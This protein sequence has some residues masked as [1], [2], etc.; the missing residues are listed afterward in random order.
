M[1]IKTRVS[2]VEQEKALNALNRHGRVVYCT[3]QDS[4]F[5]ACVPKVHHGQ[6]LHQAYVTGFDV[7]VYVV[8]NLSRNLGG[9][10]TQL[11]F[12]TFTTSIKRTHASKVKKIAE[13]L[14]GWMYN[15]NL[16]RRGY[17]MDTDFPDWFPMDSQRVIR[18]RCPLWFAA[19]RK[20]A[21]I[22]HGPMLPLNLFK[23]SVQ[24][25]YNKGKGGLDKATELE[26]RIRPRLNVSFESK[27]I[28]RLINAIVVNLWRV[29]QAF[30]I[31]PI[32][33]ESELSV[34]RIRCRLY[35]MPIQDFAYELGTS[36]LIVLF[37]ETA[38]TKS[39][40]TNDGLIPSDQHNQEM[41]GIISNMKSRNNLPLKRNT[42]RQFDY[43]PLKKLRLYQS[44]IINHALVSNK[45]GSNNTP[46]CIRRRC[47]LCSSTTNKRDTSYQCTI[48][49]VPLCMTVI[50]SGDS[51]SCFEKWH[52][53][54][55][56]RRE[57][58][59]RRSILAQKRNK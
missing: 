20:I 5:N 28:V 46:K 16:I 10:I 48:C 4:V 17:C 58:L 15:E 55:E 30:E 19:Y 57:Q 13:P 50:N 8:S 51:K 42:V 35:E 21:D 52:T 23:Q 45:D 3:F 31:R 44:S 37:M 56:L 14:L 24:F 18:S 54:Q 34:K 7:G 36:L 49:C 29:H 59:R 22:H 2:D 39:I 53:L 9:T 6:V 12:I 40:P 11:V 43:E 47:A 27:Y 25:V 33:T 41:L 32:I 38:T 1:E 26:E